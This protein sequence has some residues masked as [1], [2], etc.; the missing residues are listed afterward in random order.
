[1]ISAYWRLQLPTKAEELG[2][3]WS[4]QHDLPGPSSL[5]AGCLDCLPVQLLAEASPVFT[6]LL[7]IS[8]SLSATSLCHSGSPGSKEQNL[9]L[10]LVSRV[11]H[12]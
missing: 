4:P 3:T 10:V 2:I 6:A 7:S 8:I 1:M 12:I 9:N 5:E 11:Y